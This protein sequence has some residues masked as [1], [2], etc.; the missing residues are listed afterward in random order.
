MSQ[1]R[2]L[3]DSFDCKR[4]R[5]IK[6]IF[7]H[8]FHIINKFILLLMLKK[9]A[10]ISGLVLDQPIAD[11]EEK[12]WGNNIFKMQGCQDVLVIKLSWFWIILIKTKNTNQTH[13]TI[14]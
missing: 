14:R 1:L 3:D 11:S 13:L 10:F 2:T 12:N 4:N 5:K 6:L 9:C 8:N 7:S